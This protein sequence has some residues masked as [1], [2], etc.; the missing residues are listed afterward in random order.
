MSEDSPEWF[1]HFLANK[2]PRGS[3]FSQLTVL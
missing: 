1:G 3:M 2:N